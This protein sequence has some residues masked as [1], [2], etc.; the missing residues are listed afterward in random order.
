[1]GIKKYLIIKLYHKGASF[2]KSNSLLIR[3][4]ESIIEVNNVFSKE[5]KGEDV[6]FF[7][8]FVTGIEHSNIKIQMI[9]DVLK[10]DDLSA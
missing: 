8:G 7:K 3:S 10:D 2:V 1:M 6:S 4:L 9:I 5:Y